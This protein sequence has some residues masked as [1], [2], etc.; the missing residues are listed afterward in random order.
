MKLLR[1]GLLPGL[2]PDF[3]GRPG[4]AFPGKPALQTRGT[5]FRNHGGFNGN[6]AGAAE[7]IPHKLLA[8]VAG[9][10]D[11]GGGQG[12]PQ[13]GIVAHGPVAPLVQA[14]PGGI[15]VQDGPVIHNGELELVFIA[16]LGKPGDAVLLP[17]P[18]AGG[19]FDDGLAVRHGHELAV[20]A[21]ALHREGAVRGN[22]GLQRGRQNAL[23]QLLKGLGLEVCQDG[24]H[25]LAG[26]QAD[27]GFGHGRG[28]S[29][30]GHPAVFRLY[31]LQVQPP[32]LVCRDALQTEQAGHGKLE[33]GHSSSQMS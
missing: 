12:F 14:R 16:V 28:V 20:Q 23:E 7:G 27:V 2:L 3:G 25:P 24:Q 15:Q 31:I 22:E 4:E 18:L 26:A 32:Q 33:F 11:H 19:L 9:E 21:V 30:E 5:V 6:G 8:P 13:R 29:G 10:E 1:N 17:Q